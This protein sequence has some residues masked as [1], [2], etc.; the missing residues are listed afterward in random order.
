ML[1]KMKMMDFTKTAELYLGSS[2]DEALLQGGKKFHN[3][4]DAILFAMEE[5]APVSLRGAI[6]KVGE[7]EFTGSAVKKAYESEGFPLMRKADIA[8]SFLAR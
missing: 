4:S 5:A 3:A 1:K 6:L 8:R 7:I 2:R